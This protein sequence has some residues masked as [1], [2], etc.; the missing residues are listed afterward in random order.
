MTKNNR[1]CWTFLTVLKIDIAFLLGSI[2][3]ER[4][5]QQDGLETISVSIFYSGLFLVCFGGFWF[6][7]TESILAASTHAVFSTAVYVVFYKAVLNLENSEGWAMVVKAFKA[8]ILIPA[9]GII[10]MPLLVQLV[11]KISS[12]E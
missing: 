7:T 3:F 10:F 11:F 9:G 8:D 1:L 4:L 12:K 2:V 5:M 6:R